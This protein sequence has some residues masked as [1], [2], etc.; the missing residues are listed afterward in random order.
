M[1]GEN[2]RIRSTASKAMIGRQI[3]LKTAANLHG[4]ELENNVFDGCD[5]A[6]NCQGCVSGNRLKTGQHHHGVVLIN[7]KVC[8]QLL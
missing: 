6:V 1:S 2:P 3:A 7:V 5:E 8:L 4:K